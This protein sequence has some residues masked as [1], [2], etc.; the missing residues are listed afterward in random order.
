[1]IKHAYV[2]DQFGLETVIPLVKDKSCDLSNLDNLCAPTVSPVFSKIFELCIF[3]NLAITFIHMICIG[4]Q[5]GIGCGSAVFAVQE[6]V[7]HF[8][9][10]GLALLCSCS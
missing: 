7:K 1:M 5:E 10:R 6:T 3:I 8:T 9:D 4:F 2:P